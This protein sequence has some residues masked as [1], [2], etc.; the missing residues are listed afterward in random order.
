MSKQCFRFW[1]VQKSPAVD[2]SYKEKCL[3]GEITAQENKDSYLLFSQT[4]QI[5]YSISLEII[6][7]YS[8]YFN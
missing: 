8:W 1:T 5:Y 7:L 6:Y 3:K 2:T 4:K